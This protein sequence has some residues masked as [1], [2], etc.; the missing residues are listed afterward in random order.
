MQAVKWLTLTLVLLCLMCGTPWNWLS[1][2][3]VVGP[4]LRSRLAATE[5]TLQA[6]RTEL[7]IQHEA[8]LQA[9]RGQARLLAGHSEGPLPTEQLTFGHSFTRDPPCSRTPA[10]SINR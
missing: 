7:G 2:E 1:D 4:Q 10:V 6:V 9:V 5:A 8:T 3:M